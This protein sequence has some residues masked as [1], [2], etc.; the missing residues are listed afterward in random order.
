[1]RLSTAAALPLAAL[2]LAACTSGGG[3]T[4][5]PSGAPGGAAGSAPTAADLDGRTFVVT[6]TQGYDIVP[7][8]QIVLTFG[9][10]RLGI[11]AGCNQMGGDYRITDGTLAIGTMMM[12]EMACEEPL[13]AQDAFISAFLVGAT[14]VLDGD[15]LSLANGGVTLTATD[16]AVALPDLPLD[17]TT[18]VVDGLI[19]GDAVASMPMGVTATL[20]LVGGQVN[21]NAGC[22]R[23][24]GSAEV[25]DSTIRFGPI[26]TTKM[27]CDETAMGVEDHVLRVLTGEVT[28]SIDAGSLTLVAA[29]GAGLTAKG[30]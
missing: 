9:D 2:L 1:M 15:N 14:L 8:S 17:G 28:W 3:G 25:G 7:G 18:W 5:A 22:N 11:Q 30:A 13:M 6:G 20:E 27:A 16:K 26:A 19:M 12:T 29:D 4:P 24:G 10:G 23:G 21:V